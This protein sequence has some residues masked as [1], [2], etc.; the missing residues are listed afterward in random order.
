MTA[1]REKTK[2]YAFAFSRRE[3]TL[4]ADSTNC[5]SGS[6]NSVSGLT[7]AFVGFY[8]TF[9]GS[10]LSVVVRCEYDGKN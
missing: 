9:K 8:I 10:T 2:G 6:I 4:G 5:L 1:L 3:R 7:L